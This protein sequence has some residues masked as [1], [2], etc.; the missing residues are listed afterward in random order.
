MGIYDRLSEKGCEAADHGVRDQFV[1]SE[2]RSRYALSLDPKME[3]WRFQ[4]DGYIIK[5]GD[6]CDALILVKDGD[7]FAEVFVELKGS[8]VGHAITQLEETLK[9]G[10]FRDSDSLMRWARI[11][12]YSYPN[13]QLLNREVDKKTREFLKKYRCELLITRAD[14]LTHEMFETIKKEK[15]PEPQTININALLNSGDDLRINQAVAV[16]YLRMDASQDPFEVVNPETILLLLSILNNS[17]GVVVPGALKYIELCITKCKDALI[18]DNIIMY[19]NNL[20]ERYRGKYSDNQFAIAEEIEDRAEDVKRSLLAIYSYLK[21][22]DFFE[23]ED[24]FWKSISL[25]SG[26]TDS[27]DNTEKKSLT[28][29]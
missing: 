16:L 28:L 20:L 9:N 13:S 7:D 18:D 4:V 23:G 29:R 5:E 8:D 24:E 26:H 1:C 11:A 15:S 22:T 3:G 12:I 17:D 19:M 21:E 27:T 10:L 14:K 6:K 2:K 25:E